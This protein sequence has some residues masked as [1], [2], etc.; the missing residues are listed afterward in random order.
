MGPPPAERG[1]GAPGLAAFLAFGALPGGEPPRP[2]ARRPLPP[3]PVAR[4]RAAGKASAAA[5]A[6]RGA[7]APAAAGPMPA[8]PAIPALPGL[9]PFGAAAG[10]G[11]GSPPVPPPSKK[12]GAKTDPLFTCYE[13]WL[14]LAVESF[15][16]QVPRDAG[17]VVEI[18]TTVATR[19][20]DG[21]ALLQVRQKVPPNARGVSRGIPYAGA[22]PS[23]QCISL[24]PGFRVD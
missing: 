5:R 15:A 17:T 6:K 20:I 12:T 8:P 4:Q 16:A 14:D 9:G 10:P 7:P 24:R 1:A 2:R 23:W 18:A 11:F 21:T 3:T 13:R 22:S 19:I